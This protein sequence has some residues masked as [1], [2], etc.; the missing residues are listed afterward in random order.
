MET[1]HKFY[2]V[3]LVRNRPKSK[4]VQIPKYT[5]R[6]EIVVTTK[7]KK[8]VPESLLKRLENEARGALEAKEKEITLYAFAVAKKVDALLGTGEPDPQDHQQAMSIA[9]T[10]NKKIQELLDSAKEDAENRV[11][12]R[13]ENEK[14]DDENLFEA[15]VKL[16]TFITASVIKLA[17]SATKLAASHGTDLT[18]IVGILRTLRS[19]QTE[20]LQQ[21]KKEAQLQQDL[22]EALKNFLTEKQ[23]FEQKRASSKDKDNAGD[24]AE[25][26][27]KFYRD[28]VTKFRHS[29][30]N[31]SLNAG[32]MQAEMKSATTLK[33]GVKVGAACMKLKSE[34]RLL[35]ETLAKRERYLAELADILVKNG[36]D[37]DDRTLR[38]KIKAF[39]K[40]T[41]AEKAKNL[42]DTMDDIFSIFE[43]VKELT[44]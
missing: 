5:V 36:A 40:D 6:M 14:N 17:A 20:F 32:K 41:I 31:V 1:T 22:D 12:K 8:P 30:D 15:R 16:I 26:A 7:R 21:S 10:A 13:L 11:T 2:I 35:S 29:I 34:V 9:S 37:V 25:K 28:N 4:L 19:L 23:K 39:N 18:A 43:S 44:A 24:K 33:E 38:D 3:D 27:R 42:S